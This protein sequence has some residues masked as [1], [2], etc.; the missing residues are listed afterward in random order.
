MAIIL[1]ATVVRLMI[2]LHPLVSLAE[3]QASPD[4]HYLVSSRV[5][6]VHA[7]LEGLEGGPECGLHAPCGCTGAA[8]SAR[9]G[10]P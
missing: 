8:V 3:K 7:T 4:G 9:Y 5:A 2:G 6:E 10:N 1:E